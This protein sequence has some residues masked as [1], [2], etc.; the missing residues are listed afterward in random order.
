M[1]G[2]SLV[3]TSSDDFEPRHLTFTTT[4]RAHVNRHIKHAGRRAAPHIHG[5]EMS[6]IRKHRGRACT[7]NDRANIV[8]AATEEKAGATQPEDAPC[9]VPRTLCAYAGKSEELEAGASGRTPP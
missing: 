5:F 8:L 9:L 6:T 4:H 2:G 3:S 1:M 7:G